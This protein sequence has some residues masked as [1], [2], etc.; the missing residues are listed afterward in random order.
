M[1]QKEE[2]AVTV[3]MLKTPVMLLILAIGYGVLFAL[4]RHDCKKTV[5]R[6]RGKRE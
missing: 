3:M 1:G 4:Y 2:K 5:H 6:G